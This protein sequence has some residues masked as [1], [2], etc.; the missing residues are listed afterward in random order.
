MGESGLLVCSKPSTENKNPINNQMTTFIY[1]ELDCRSVHKTDLVG[2]LHSEVADDIDPTGRGSGRESGRTTQVRGVSGRPYNRTTSVNGTLKEPA[3]FK[4]GGLELPNTTGERGLRSSRGE[5]D[6]LESDFCGFGI[7][8][9]KKGGLGR[10]SPNQ[11]GIG[12]SAGKSLAGPKYDGSAGRQTTGHQDLGTDG[13]EYPVPSRI[14]LY[15]PAPVRASVPSDTPR[16]RVELGADCMEALGNVGAGRT[17]WTKGCKTAP[18]IPRPLLLKENHVRKKQFKSKNSNLHHSR[19]TKQS[20]FGAIEPKSSSSTIRYDASGERIWSNREK[21]LQRAFGKPPRLERSGA[22]SPEEQQVPLSQRG[23]LGPACAMVEE[24]EFELIGGMPGRGRGKGSKGPPAGG[25]GKGSDGPPAGRGTGHEQ[26]PRRSNLNNA[27]A[28]RLGGGVRAVD[29][30][31]GVRCNGCGGLGHKVKQCP[32]RRVIEGDCRKCGVKGHMVNDCGFSP[33]EIARRKFLEISRSMGGGGAFARLPSGPVRGNAARFTVAGFDETADRC[34]DCY[35]TVAECELVGRCSAQIAY[36]AM[37][38]GGHP[39]AKGEMP[40]LYDPAEGKVGPEERSLADRWLAVSR[41]VPM[42]SLAD[43]WLSFSRAEPKDDTVAAGPVKSQDDVLTETVSA[44]QDPP[45]HL[46]VGPQ[47]VFGIQQRVK[48]LAEKSTEEPEAP[49]LRRAE[50]YEGYLDPGLL[51]SRVTALKWMCIV[52]GAEHR[53]NVI[54]CTTEGCWGQ[55]PSLAGPPPDELHP[56]IPP[57]LAGNDV[58]SATGVCQSLML[59]TLGN[60]APDA[61][62]LMRTPLMAAQGEQAAFAARVASG[63]YIGVDLSDMPESFRLLGFDVTKAASRPYGQRMEVFERNRMLIMQKGWQRYFAKRTSFLGGNGAPPRWDFDPPDVGLV[64]DHGQSMYSRTGPGLLEQLVNYHFL[65]SSTG[66]CKHNR[67]S[68]HVPN[69]P[70]NV[71][72]GMAMAARSLAPVFIP[73]QRLMLVLKFTLIFVVLMTV[74]AIVFGLLLSGSH[75]ASGFHSN[76]TEFGFTAN[77]PA[78]EREH[79]VGRTGARATLAILIALPICFLLV[80]YVSARL[81]RLLEGAVILPRAALRLTFRLSPP[82]FPPGEDVR[83]MGTRVSAITA[84][85][86]ITTVTVGY[87]T[88]YH[89]GCG[90]FVPLL[91][92]LGLEALAPVSVSAYRGLSSGGLLPTDMV[93]W[94]PQ[95]RVDF[96]DDSFEA[97]LSVMGTIVGKLDGAMSPASRDAAILSAKNILT[98]TNINSLSRHVSNSQVLANEYVMYSGYA[99]GF[100]VGSAEVQASPQQKLARR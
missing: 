93:H 5:M 29:G 69:F 15:G 61:T 43:R 62:W 27:G 78:R 51:L 77:V 60:A 92:A 97:S 8:T 58:V 31:E 33:E 95:P 4:D 67:L 63:A 52:C 22:S 34:L 82:H 24:D 50:P 36:D 55:H 35:A 54:Y 98:G 91:S 49:A 75:Y 65:D 40:T 25:R 57:S 14:V 68:S 39:E 88:M 80:G 59:P 1:K 99:Q 2:T 12:L 85:P 44:L 73:T 9:I 53:Q 7:S 13:E 18:L 81:N 84:H 90:F 72:Q 83:A 20:I 87:E 10:A 21:R 32:N 45:S 94:I 37:M 76:T 16:P 79:G 38:G 70:S 47:S 11:T 6:E 3:D 74:D 46:E 86:V 26:H 19:L 100:G 41:A 66:L 89:P 96:L 28:N 56:S 48:R 23:S 30:A 17:S 71:Q 64:A 42:E